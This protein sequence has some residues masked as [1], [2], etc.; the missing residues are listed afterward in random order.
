[1]E[2]ILAAA[3]Y[4]YRLAQVLHAHRRALNMP[5]RSAHAPGTLPSRLA[6]LLRLPQRKVHWM[7]LAVVDVYARASLKVL[8][9]LARQLAIVGIRLRIEVHI[10]IYLVCKALLFEL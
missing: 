2:Q 3:V 8:Q 7:A 6:G 9:I 5:T 1:E 4:V 10:A